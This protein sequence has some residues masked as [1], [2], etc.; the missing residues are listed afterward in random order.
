[1][2][3]DSVFLSPRAVPGEESPSKKMSVDQPLSSEDRRHA[4]GLM[5]V[6]HTGEI[7]AQALYRGQAFLARKTETKEALWNA[8]IEE[9]NHLIW[10]RERL[11]ELGAHPSHLNGLWYSASFLIGLIAASVGD[12]WSNGFVVETER[13]VD[14]HLGRH[15]VELPLQDERSRAILIKMQEEEQ[16]HAAA[17]EKRGGRDLPAWVKQ[18]M[19]LKSQVMTR[20]AYWV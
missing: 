14:A 15:L 6:D 11:D 18:L 13:Q 1:M 20:T 16:H 2:G 8:A 3:L 9:H 4:S 17:A 19:S 10:C 5:R 12:D 7:C